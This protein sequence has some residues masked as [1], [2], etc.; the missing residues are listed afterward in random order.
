MNE[1]FFTPGPSGLY[2]TVE[3]HLKEALKTNVPSISHRSK[4]Y[5]KIQEETTASLK[6]L[7]QIPD[8]FTIGYTSSAT[9][10]W[11]RIS[12]NLI[13]KQSLH[14]INGAFSEKFHTAATA[15]GKNAHAITVDAG[16]HHD[17][18]T[19][20]VDKEVEL[21]GL[22]QNETST[23]AAMP[24]QDIVHLRK[25]YPDPLLVVDAVSSLPIP[26][27]DFDQLD[28]LYFSVQKS[29]GLPAGLGVWSFNE[30]CLEKAE[31]MKTQGK[32]QESY[33]SIL[34]IAKMAKKHQ[35]TC[36]PN[37]LNI[38]LLGKVVQDMLYRGIEKIRQEAQYKSSLLYH[39]FE[40]HPRLAPFVQEKKYRS[41]TVGVAQVDGGSTRL[42][43]ALSKKGWH[44]GNGYGTFKNQH[45]RIANFPTHSKEQMEML[46]DEIR[47]LDF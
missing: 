30:R 44:I 29:F 4:R 23:G 18:H 20:K 27:F 16:T 5:V 13:A 40:S 7:L 14:L 33:N 15:K 22:A 36:T 34:K 38:Y 46:V 1:I 26:A 45:I 19:L 25:Q 8:D 43:D 17:V 41:V 42:I 21:I 39:L 31:T 12:E 6:E 35:T 3:Q 47:Q 9:E 28:S 11:D 10:I 2:F 32:Y 37:V 24:E